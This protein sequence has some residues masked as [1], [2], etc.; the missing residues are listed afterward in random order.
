[1]RTIRYRHA[2]PDDVAACIVIRGQTRENAIAEATLNALGITRESWAQGV[3]DGALPGVVAEA[4]GRIAGYCFG[5]A[6]SGEIVVLALLPAFEGAGVGKTLLARVMQLLQGQG[7][8]RLFLGC[9]SD[10][11]VR[12]HGF[13]RH[14]GW[15]STGEVDAY[16]DEVLEYR[17]SSLSA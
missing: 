5:D 13:Y 9:N 14:L 12:S 8:T 15:T 3:A 2:R 16:G 7:H 11:A 1:M 10:P 4:D 17:F 6:Q